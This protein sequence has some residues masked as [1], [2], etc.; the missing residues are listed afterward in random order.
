[1]TLFDNE[2][3]AIIAMRE[4]WRAFERGRDR[5]L[6]G[7]ISCGRR[8][9]LGAL[10]ALAVPTGGFVA[11]INYAPEL[12]DEFYVRAFLA[13]GGGG[14]VRPRRSERL[15]RPRGGCAPDPPG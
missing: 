10:F 5:R 6:P 13:G 4:K 7:V 2:V 11:V 8:D 9:L 3:A 12:L 14:S 1:M 15:A